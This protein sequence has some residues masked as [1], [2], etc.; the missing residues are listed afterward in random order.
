MSRFLRGVIYLTM[1]VIATLPLVN[2]GLG[3][4]FSWLTPSVTAALN[5]L[6][7]SIAMMFLFSRYE[8]FDMVA[9][10][11][12]RFTIDTRFLSIDRLIERVIGEVNRK[13]DSFSMSLIESR[14]VSKEE[15]SRTLEKIVATAYRLF[16]AESAELALFDKESGLYHS[17]FVLGTPMRT[18]S[19]AMLSGAAEGSQHIHRP[20]VLV[21]PLA[22]AGSVL[23]TLR[24]LL[25]KGVAPRS[26]DQEVL[27]LLA[28]QGSLALINARYTE[29]L[30]KM[31]RA[32]DESMKAKTGFLA[33]LSH[34]IRAPL[35]V[36]MNAVELI[37]DGLCGSINQDQ[38][39]TLKMVHSNG[40]HL[41]ELI[42]D[43]LDY[44]KVE[45]GKISPNR[46]DI[47][48]HDLL[49]D[50]CNV[51]RA[52][53]D[54]KGHRLILKSC[55]DVLVVSCDRRHARQ[56]II[57]LLTN[58]IKYT[59]DGG[60]I[61]VW[62]ERAPGGKIKVHVKDSGVGID[63][64]ERDKVFAP[65]ERLENSY[66]L[67]QI[68]TGLGMS[69]TKRLAE[70]NGAS[71]DFTSSP[72]NGSDFWLLFQG[73]KASTA[74]KQ[75]VI[76]QPMTFKGKGEVIL[77]VEKDDGERTMMAKYLSHNGFKI[78]TADNKRSALDIFKSRKIDLAIIDNATV[79]DLK[80]DMVRSIRNT[81]AGGSIPI[82]LVSSRAFVFDIERYLKTGIDRCLVKPIK[83]SELGMICRQLL[84]GTYL[85]EV[86][87][88]N[89]KSLI[90]KNNKLIDDKKVIISTTVIKSN[91][92]RK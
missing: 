1:G 26:I 51:V 33:N 43:V 53:A 18:S 31:R 23:G 86:V 50:V 75:D 4:I 8:L 61:E 71:I 60:V 62:S 30:V 13:N 58:A 81:T 34:E 63:E 36:I 7:W 91:E 48:L 37:L 69:L 24:I 92:I 72:G 79:D 28:L 55:E 87:D 57:N 90:D 16:E 52:Q 11:A 45:A 46:V 67:N 88:E 59:Q 6:G 73:V 21:Q 66:S 27:R 64:I 85:G 68:G 22:F 65:F 15:L 74:I 38:T 44:A 29:E 40:E 47:D 25:R 5:L 17:A 80:D 89:D 41:L 77:L 78:A 3:S 12:H 56:M 39:E 84:D 35:G 83:L 10:I 82:V 42:N 32:S 19:Q 70:V 20:D 2:L 49:K 14:I 54:V 9:K 76:Y